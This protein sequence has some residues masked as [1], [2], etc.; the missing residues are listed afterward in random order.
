MAFYT[1][2]DNVKQSNRPDRYSKEWKPGKKPDWLGIYKCQ[3][4]G[5]EDVFN[6]ECEKVPPCAECS[7]RTSTW[8]LLVRAEDKQ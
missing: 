8:K 3:R 5:F 7:E 2:S 1:D 4:C 6:R